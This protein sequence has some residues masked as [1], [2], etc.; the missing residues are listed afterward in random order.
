MNKISSLFDQDK[1]KEIWLTIKRNKFRSFLTGFGVGWGIF[2]FVIMFGLGNGI[3]NGL[4]QNVEGVANSVFVFPGTT[5]MEYKGFNMGRNWELKLSDVEM[6]RKN[7]PQIQHISGTVEGFYTGKI[8]RGER[9]GDYGFKG[10]EEN[11]SKM[12]K[13]NVLQGREFNR[14]DMQEK[15]K[16]CLIG[17]TVYEQLFEKDEDAIG[18]Q[19]CVNRLYYNVVGV[20]YGSDEINISGRRL[21][22]SVLIP[23][24][25]MQQVNNMGQNIHI[26]SIAV[27]DDVKVTEIEPAIKDLLKSAHNI[28]PQDDAAINMF[29][30]QEMFLMFRYL[31][32]GVQIL[33]WIVGMG[34]LFAG[35]VG[36]SNIMLVSIRERTK[37]IGI[38]RALGAKP[39]VILKQIMGESITLTFIA[40]YAGFFFAVLILEIIDKVTQV[41]DGSMPMFAD[42]QISFPMAIGALVV[43]IVFGLLAGIIPAQNALKIKAIDAL[44]D[45]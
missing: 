36:V 8:T 45:E 18:K 37:E 41:S 39:S 14:L 26:L 24:T 10:V 29:N 23:I 15:R 28:A 42:P 20:I 9:F 22:E 1:F 17:K 6:L 3:F 44:R 35:V 13:I 25:T 4:Q 40:G 19:I 43:L 32:L 21:K 38:R 31:F 34:T 5:T 30:L 16:I 2:M 7:I 11:F 33:I 12:E 27:Y